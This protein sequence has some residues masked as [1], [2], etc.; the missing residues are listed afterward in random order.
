M[1][2]ETKYV[3]DKCEKSQ[4]TGEQM[5]DVSISCEAV[6]TYRSGYHAPNKYQ[7]VMW[8]RKCV[9]EMRVMT[10]LLRADQPAEPPTLEG[11]IQEIV[12]QTLAAERE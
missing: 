2:I 12:R 1:P 4:E 9:D 5:W 8:C 10:P 6:S 7:K 3:C 11:I